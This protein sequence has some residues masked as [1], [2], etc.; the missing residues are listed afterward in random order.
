MNE[1]TGM[2]L[3]A[4]E[5]ALVAHLIADW[6]FQNNWMARNKGRLLH[7]AAWVHGLIH[8]I[9]LGLALDLRAGIFLG[10]LHMLIDTR[11]PLTW[12]MHNIKGSAD[13]PEAASIAVWADQVIHIVSIAVWIS[14]LAS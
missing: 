11:V 2:T 3:T 13:E 10:L 5:R 7:P 8:G 14:W 6:L 4:F 9:C 1:L 12:W